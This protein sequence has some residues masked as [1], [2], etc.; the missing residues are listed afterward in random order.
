VKQKD[1]TVTLSDIQLAA[2]IDPGRKHDFTF[3]FDVRDGNPNGDP[4]A[5]GMP[6]IDPETTRGLVT[7]VAIKRK[8][9]N[10]V[11][12]L[13]DG[14]P[15]YDIYVEAGVALNAQHERAYATLGLSPGAVN[16]VP[17]ARDWMCQTFYD[18]RLFGAVMS[19]GR[20]QDGRKGAKASC[21][22][23]QGPVQLTFSRSEDPV[24]TQEHG[25]TRVTQTRQADI[26]KGE[27]TE[28]GSKHTIPYGLYV[29]HGHFS[30]PLAHRTG[31]T[32]DDL[33]L[34]WR[35]F[36]LMFEHDRASSR[37]EMAL[38]G[39]HVFTHSDAYGS[40]PA[41]VLFDQIRI[42]R[43]TQGPARAY[44]DYIVSIDEDNIPDGVIL[45][46]LVQ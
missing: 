43:A 45:T 15:G 38:R 25:I 8:I 44:A 16:S 3:I 42:G 34:L 20:D 21:G 31:V 11:T 19:T 12:L 4:D 23:V 9:R 39:L 29:G 46:S 17:K 33:S 14:K 10:M 35:A 26:D 41:H 28:M 36:T 40:A 7:D 32:S 27:S 37:G 18:V 1:S 2:H 6:R 13:A 24:F 5:G 22:R 30:A